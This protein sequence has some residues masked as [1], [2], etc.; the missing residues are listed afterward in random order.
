MK[1]FKRMNVI[2]KYTPKIERMEQ[3]IKDNPSDYQTKISLAKLYGTEY[4]YIK[5]QRT[6]AMKR[7]IARFKKE[8][9]QELAY[10]KHE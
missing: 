1:P 8:I 7:D 9:E 10:E 3:H 6:N 4:E 2:S 5:R